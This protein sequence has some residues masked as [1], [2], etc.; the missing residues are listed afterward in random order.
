MRV[1][2]SHGR[3]ARRVTTEEKSIAQG[4]TSQRRPEADSTTLTN[5]LD[6]DAEGVEIDTDEFAALADV[7]RTRS[8]TCVR[9]LRSERES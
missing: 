3:M 2:M 7:E 9:S 6:S 4:K 5:G 1:V 8:M